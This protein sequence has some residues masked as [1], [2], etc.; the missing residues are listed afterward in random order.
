MTPDIL[1]ALRTI[2]GDPHVLTGTDVSGRYDGYPQIEPMQA[3]C[4]V[5]PETT[6]QVSA[7]LAL[8]DRQRL[9]VVPQG[10]RTGLVGGA[11]AA[12]GGR[13]RARS[14]GARRAGPGCW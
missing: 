10:G 3:A 6:E 4:I 1:D 13:R 14:R 7:I 11:R 12:A 2:V 9:K 5:R 8:C